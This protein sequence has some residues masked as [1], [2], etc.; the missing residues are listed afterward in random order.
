MKNKASKRQQRATGSEE[1]ETE[2]KWIREGRKR[3]VFLI[4]KRFIRDLEFRRGSRIC[5]TS[6]LLRVLH[7]FGHVSDFFAFFNPPE[8]SRKTPRDFPSNFNRI[9]ISS[10]YTRS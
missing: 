7:R 3:T 9:C 4:M 2:E 10:I 6:G 5:P 1:K 8:N